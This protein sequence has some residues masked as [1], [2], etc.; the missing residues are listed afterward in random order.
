VISVNLGQ[1]LED[2]FKKYLK[3]IHEPD[4][5]SL[6]LSGSIMV[7]ELRMPLVSRKF[8][9]TPIYN[10]QFFIFWT[11]CLQPERPNAE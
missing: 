11:F 5:S 3:N 7:P 9:L 10:V 6:F 8:A 1:E 4:L 2:L